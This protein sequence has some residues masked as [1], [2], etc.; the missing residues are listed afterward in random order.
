MKRHREEF[1]AYQGKRRPN[2]VNLL[3][4]QHCLTMCQV[5]TDLYPHF[6]SDSGQLAKRLDYA[7]GEGVVIVLT[8]WIT[9]KTKI[10]AQDQ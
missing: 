1:W 9:I 6:L 10:T 8:C 3:G 5:N 2:T 7:T 4:C